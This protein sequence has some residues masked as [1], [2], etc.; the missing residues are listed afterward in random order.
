MA[1][2][3]YRVASLPPFL[4]CG[5][6]LAKG[7]GGWIHFVVFASLRILLCTVRA[8]DEGRINGVIP[9]MGQ[10]MSLLLIVTCLQFY[11]HN[12]CGKK[13]MSGVFDFIPHTSKFSLQ[14]ST[15]PLSYNSNLQEFQNY[16]KEQLMSSSK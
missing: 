5:T 9:G 1:V 7:G 14:N 10:V 16:F 15:K 8:G 4:G 3:F 11:P 13:M 12:H 2:V 6:H